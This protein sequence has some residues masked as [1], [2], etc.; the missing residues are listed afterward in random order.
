MC[1]TFNSIVF[2]INSSELLE[3]ATADFM[4]ATV[5][6]NRVLTRPLEMPWLM[7]NIFTP[8]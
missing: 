2:L 3:L 7:L 6:K 5:A 4:A 8:C 1:V